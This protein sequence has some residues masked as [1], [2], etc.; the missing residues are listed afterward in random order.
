MRLADPGEVIDKFCLTYVSS[1]RKSRANRSKAAAVCATVAEGE[2]DGHG[3][4]SGGEILH[5][6]DGGIPACLAGEG[7]DDVWRDDVGVGELALRS[8]SWRLVA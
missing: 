8:G 6:E 7:V 2:A 1:G 3:G 4:K 5:A